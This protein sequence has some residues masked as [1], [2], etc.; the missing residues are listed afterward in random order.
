MKKQLLIVVSLLCTIAVYGQHET[1]FSRA[2]ILGGFAGPLFEFG[3]INGEYNPSMGGGAG[4][5]VD[6]FFVGVYGLGSL[7]AVHHAIHNDDG[8]RADLA[9]GG[10]W[11]GYTPHTFRLVHPYSSLKVGWGYADIRSDN[12]H[13][14]RSGDGIFALVPEVGMEMNITKYCRLSGSIGYRMI[15]DVDQLDNLANKDFSS[16]TGQLTL[17]FGWFGRHRHRAEELPAKDTF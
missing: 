16:L 8:F 17:R 13:F 3:N 10:L 2:R 6:D 9:H 1:L 14:V 15:T 7:D 11:F 5:I 4:L 12:F